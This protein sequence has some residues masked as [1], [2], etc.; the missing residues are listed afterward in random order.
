MNI[1]LL[2]WLV[3][4]AYVIAVPVIVIAAGEMDTP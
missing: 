3:G 4:L 2:L 1:G